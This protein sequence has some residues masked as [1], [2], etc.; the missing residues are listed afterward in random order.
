MLTLIGDL[1]ASMF[2]ELSIRAA[3]LD[4]AIE[5]LGRHSVR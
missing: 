4:L 2:S 5:V 1:D 3:L